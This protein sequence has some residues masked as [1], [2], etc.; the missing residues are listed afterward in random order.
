MVSNGLT[1][2]GENLGILSIMP[3]DEKHRLFEL[4]EDFGEEDFRPL[5]E[6]HKENKEE[7]IKKLLKLKDKKGRNL[8]SACCFKGNSKLVDYL[9]NL[10]A[11]HDVPA[12][13]LDISGNDALELACI[14]GFNLTD[15]DSQKEDNAIPQY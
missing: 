4:A 15:E 13:V 6:M 5:I 14:R 9:L 11:E 12:L 10:Y 2:L 1:N 8:L 7:E 3:K